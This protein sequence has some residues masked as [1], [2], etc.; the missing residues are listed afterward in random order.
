[1]ESHILKDRI[2][3]RSIHLKKHHQ[4]RL[5]RESS[6]EKRCDMVRMQLIDSKMNV[7]LSDANVAG[8][9]GS[10]W[11]SIVTVLLFDDDR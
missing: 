7:E 2:T 4:L 3:S 5:A 6:Y 11:I 8:L 1:M 9:L 10:E